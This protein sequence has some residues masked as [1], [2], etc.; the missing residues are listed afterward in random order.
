M[1]KQDRPDPRD[2]SEALLEKTGAALMS[3]DFE[4]FQACFILPQ[5][6]ETFEGLQ[7]IETTAQLRKIYDAVRRY[8]ARLAVTYMAR[9]CLEAEYR[10]DDTVE[11]THETRL[12]SGQRLIQ[13]PFPVFS[14]LK[15]VDGVWHVAS[16]KYAIV[17]APELSQALKGGSTCQDA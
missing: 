14:V 12:L 9:N 5:E 6:M 1:A 2:V 7:R 17:D 15:R 16:T 4:T 3:G 8:H 13:R 11:A 10:D